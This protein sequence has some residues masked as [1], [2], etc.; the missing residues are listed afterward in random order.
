MLLSQRGGKG[1]SWGYCGWFPIVRGWIIDNRCLFKTFPTCVTSTHSTIL[2]TLSTYNLKPLFF[3]YQP[4]HCI[5]LPFDHSRHR[6]QL[7]FSDAITE[8]HDIA[9]HFT[10][11]ERS[12]LVLAWL[13]S[14]SCLL[15]IS[16][17]SE[18]DTFYS[19]IFLY[20]AI[21]HIMEL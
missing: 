21:C 17:D 10:L 4:N 19:L 5:C 20:C 7:N 13:L 18:S 2:I 12:L 3:I 16:V 9:C 15:N 8:Y 6:T 1:D 11:Y 14:F